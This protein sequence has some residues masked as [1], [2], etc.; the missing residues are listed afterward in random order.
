MNIWRRTQEREP[1]MAGN[2]FFKSAL[3]LGQV[4]ESVSK[5]FFEAEFLQLQTALGPL[6]S[7]QMLARKKF[8]ASF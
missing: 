5:L 1:V 4:C 2:I 8:L 6:K 3:F 7:C